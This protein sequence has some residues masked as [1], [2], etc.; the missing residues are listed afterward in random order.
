[1]ALHLTNDGEGVN[2]ALLSLHQRR[3]KLLNLLAI[4]FPLLGAVVLLLHS[5]A[6]LFFAAH[7]H[8]FLSHVVCTVL[9]KTCGFPRHCSAASTSL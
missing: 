2:A 3:A 4:L 6:P 5:Y 9:E 7:R 1:M 8:G